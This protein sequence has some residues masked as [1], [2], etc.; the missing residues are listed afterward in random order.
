MASFASEYSA[1]EAK[2]ETPAPEVGEAENEAQE[3]QT[4]T[5]ECQ[6]QAGDGESAQEE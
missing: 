4:E 5:G 3:V 2:P 6:G 1:G